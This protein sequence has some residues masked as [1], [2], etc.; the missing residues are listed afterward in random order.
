[1]SL[2]NM[3]ELMDLDA[4]RAPTA[5]VKGHEEARFWRIE[6]HVP[7]PDTLPHRRLPKR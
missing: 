7:V 3:I 1:M 6:T 4:R 2:F 5:R